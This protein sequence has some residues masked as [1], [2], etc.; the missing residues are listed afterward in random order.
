[1]FLALTGRGAEEVDGAVDDE[2]PRRRFGRK[3]K[4]A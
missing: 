4:A 2:A 3:R 1:V